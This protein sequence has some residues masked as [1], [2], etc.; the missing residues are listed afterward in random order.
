[1]K[2]AGSILIS[3]L[4]ITASMGFTMK[5]HFCMDC[6]HMYKHAFILTT[7]FSHAEC[8]GC[9]ENDCH[10]DTSCEIS[11]EAEISH[12]SVELT[13]LIPSTEKQISDNIQPEITHLNNDIFLAEYQ[14]ANVFAEFENTY[15]ELK[16]PP[17]YSPDLY[18]LH[19]ILII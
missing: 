10:C 12:F 1:M 17:E 18:I 4:V 14:S 8:S 2:R 3:L 16:Y 9:E 13:S 19:S 11:H 7:A 5:K 15:T 6:G